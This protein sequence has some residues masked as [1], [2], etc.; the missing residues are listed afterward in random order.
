MKYEMTQGEEFVYFWRHNM[1]GSFMTSLAIAISLADEKNKDRIAL[2]FPEQV[3]AMR[4]FY[5]VDDWWKNL[6]DKVDATKKENHDESNI[7]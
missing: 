1:L 2:G 5:Y 4:S 7:S 3:E 6:K